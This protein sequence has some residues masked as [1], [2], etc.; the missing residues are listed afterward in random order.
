MKNQEQI[1]N[2][3]FDS[4]KRKWYYSD[5]NSYANYQEEHGDKNIAKKCM[6]VYDYENY[7][8]N[9]QLSPNGQHFPLVNDISK[10][11]QE[12]N[13]ME[14]SENI[15]YVNILYDDSLLTGIQAPT[16][17]ESNYI[18]FEPNW[19]NADILD[20]DQRNYYYETTDEHTVVDLSEHDLQQQQQNLSLLEQPRQEH[21]TGM[22]TPVQPMQSQ[23]IYLESNDPRDDSPSAVALGN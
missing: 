19:N 14:L 6:T 20:L 21:L 2:H 13:S 23:N 22:T 11:T 7:Q 5:P 15:E 10:Q 4:N 1:E 12:L 16:V 18:N 8:P 17:T 3:R 9:H